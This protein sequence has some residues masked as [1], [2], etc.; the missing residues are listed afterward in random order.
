MKTAIE[1]TNIS[2]KF[3]NFYANKNISFNILD[4][5]VHA[6]LGENGAG[7]STLMNILFGIYQPTDG[8]IKIDGQAVKIT[9]PNIAKE[10]KIGMVHQH[11]QLVD[12]F[13]VAQNVVLGNEITHGLSIDM[14]KT[15]QLVQ[16]VIDKYKFD[17]KADQL[18]SELTIGQQQKVEILKMLFIDAKYLIFDEPTGA[19]TPQETQELLSIIKN[20]KENGKTIIL[21]THKLNEIKAIAD[22]CT[23]IRKGNTIATVDVD[24]ATSEELA[25]L[26]VGHEVEFNVN[27]PH[28]KCGDV[29][30]KLDDVCVGDKVHN[31]SLELHSG[32][33][34]G[35]AG[36]DGNGQ[37]ELIEAI[38]G[39]RKITHGKVFLNN[40]DITNK[41][42]RKINE[43]NIAYVPQDRHKVGLVLDFDI[44]D[45]AVLKRY[46]QKPYSKFGIL[47]YN[48]INKLANQLIENYDIRCNDGI[49]SQT[50]GMSGG[51][52]QKLI[53]GREFSYDPEVIILVQPT[54][55]VDVGAISNI[56]KDI[57]NELANGKAILLVS[58]ELSEIM[59]LS[60]KICVMHG[61]ENM[62]ILDAIT[63]NEEEIG[64]LMAGMRGS[65]E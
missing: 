37:V 27:K 47:N 17:I 31:I 59:Q 1:L 2:K 52:Q 42:V 13:T 7:K 22:R 9:N 49:H 62:G 14:K 29:K 21:I 53:I 41:S 11:F 23:V 65:N 26:M 58:L 19:L 12:S 57:M 45:N 54:R 39:M 38:M 48:E 33:I 40:V 8:E 64:L 4:G 46:Y 15:N 30:L 35:I 50:R 32:E 6:I 34:L 20:L 55:G 36:V 28:V 5:E 63:T 18:V 3:G 25:A 10:L 43:Q 16:E 44:A 51:N 24:T 60:D 61:G 56:H